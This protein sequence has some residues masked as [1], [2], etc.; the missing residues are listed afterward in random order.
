MACVVGSRQV[1]V[2]VVVVDHPEVPFQRQAGSELH[3]P[4]TCY[5][6]PRPKS[7]D[8][9]PAFKRL[10]RSYGVTS[11]V[12]GHVTVLPSH[13]NITIIGSAASMIWFLQP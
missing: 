4:S 10:N 5:S 1:V 3:T 11:T 9:F 13:I 12:D 8:D 7:D 6:S 2:V